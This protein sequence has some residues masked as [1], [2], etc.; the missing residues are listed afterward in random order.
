[1]RKVWAVAVNTIKQALRMKIAAVFT[2]LLLVLLP[3]MG[4][5][6]TGDGTLKGRLQTFV[7][8]GLSLTGLLLCLFTVIVSVYTLTNDL[9]RRQIYTVLTKPIRRYQLIVGKLLGIVLVDIMLLILF[10]ATIYAITIYI[11][12]FVKAD[13]QM[14]ADVD[15]QFYTARAGLRPAEADVSE[16]VVQ[17]YEKLRKSSQLPAGLEQNVS[18]QRNYKKEI[19][20]RIKLRKRAARPGGEL[21]W[22]FYNVKPLDVRQSLFVRFKYDVSANP[23]DLMIYGRWIIG[24]DR[25]LSYAAG[26][27]TPIYRADRKD[28]IRTFYEIE[29]PA[30]AVADD[31]YLGVDFI[32]PPINNTV[33]IFPP[34]GGIEVLYKADTFTANFIRAVLLILIRL[35]FLAV[36]GLLA[37]AFLSFPVAILLCLSVFLTANISGFILESFEYVSK[38]LSGVYSSVF[39]SLIQLLPQFDKF[40]TSKFL[41]PG[42]LLSWSL[43]GKIALSTLCIK[44]LLLLLLAMLIFSR[45]EV[46]KVTV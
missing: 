34:K 20:R 23:P 1:M 43:L 9:K 10:S 11:P 24:D 27:K 3:V 8:Y 31:G 13:K 17:E 46:A 29:V 33:V 16:E 38:E 44:T 4:L 7:S 30:D 18:A 36:L 28:L 25:Q 35:I 41:V 22:Q 19:E 15:N 21:L 42:R 2:V 37:A 45:R 39:K 6:M 32:N 40:S 5:K 26:I 14:L 12:R